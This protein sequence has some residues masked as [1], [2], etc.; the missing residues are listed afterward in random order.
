MNQ[1]VEGGGGGALA[2]LG[3]GEED[4]Y[5]RPYF[6]NF[7][8]RDSQFGSPS[9]NFVSP[10]N[11]PGAARLRQSNSASSSKKTRSIKALNP[12]RNLNLNSNASSVLN[13]NANSH[14]QFNSNTNS[15]KG[16]PRM[17]DPCSGASSTQNRPAGEPAPNLREWNLAFSPIRKDESSEIL[18]LQGA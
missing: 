6:L 2:K 3:P 13:S 5:P 7:A 10:T 14:L 16:G 9:H 11:H 15:V 4:Q 1:S 12:Y 8:G 17:F 18:G